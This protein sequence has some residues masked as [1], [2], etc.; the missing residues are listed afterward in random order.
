MDELAKIGFDV[1]GVGRQGG[2]QRGEHGFVH[3]VHLRRPSSVDRRSGDSGALRDV[4]EAQPRVADVDQQCA[5]GPEDGVV[6]RGIAWAAHCG[7]GV[8]VVLAHSS[9]PSDE[10]PLDDR[11][12]FML[13]VVL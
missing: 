8:L 2:L 7:R 11:G 6:D 4:L 10:Q 12:L 1:A 9:S 13:Q 3:E 5:R